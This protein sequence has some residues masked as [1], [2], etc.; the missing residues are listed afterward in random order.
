MPP[1]IV[2][3]DPSVSTSGQTVEI[4]R[5]PLVI[6]GIVMDSAGLPVVTI[7][8]VS[9]ALRPKSSQAAEF[10]SDPLTL[11]P[12]DNRVE[13][14]ATSPAHTEAKVVL[15][16][17]FTPP[18]PPAPVVPPPANTRALAKADILRLLSG[19]VPSARVASLVKDRGIKFAPTD[20]DINELRAAGGKDDLI[21]ALK[22]STTT[23]QR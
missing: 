4:N 3:V 13:I 17:R 9:A 21:N 10:T 12:G 1:A 11:Q 8:G 14:T 6:H 16:A 20:S 15:L 19:E 18:A 22:Q 23:A 2:L 5:S 7:N